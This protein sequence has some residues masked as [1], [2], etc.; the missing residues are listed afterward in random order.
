M[1]GQDEAVALISSQISD[2]KIGHAYLFSGPKGVGKTS[3]ARII[4]KELGCDPIFDELEIDEKTAKHLLLKH[5][6]VRNVLII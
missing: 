3:L 6:S 2:D 5:K 4:A 1:V